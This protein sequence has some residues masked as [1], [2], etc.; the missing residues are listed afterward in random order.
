VESQRENVWISAGEDLRPRNDEKGIW[1]YLDLR[2]FG[3]AV[4]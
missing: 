2:K 4:A 3:S 1:W